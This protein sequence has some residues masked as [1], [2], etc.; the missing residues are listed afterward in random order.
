MRPIPIVP[1]FFAVLSTFSS[2]QAAS[3]ARQ[4]TPSQDAQACYRLI[5]DLNVQAASIAAAAKNVTATRTSFHRVASG[6]SSTRKARLGAFQS[7]VERLNALTAQFQVGW[8]R[9]RANCVVPTNR[10]DLVASKFLDMQRNVSDGLSSFQKIE[11]GEYLK[12]VEPQKDCGSCTNPWQEHCNQ[13]ICNQ[14]CTTC[15]PDPFSWCQISCHTNFLMCMMAGILKETDEVA[16]NV[17]HNM[18]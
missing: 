11:P 6:D 1:T 5:S 10:S 2:L 4:P 7:D 17:I 16:K 8:T 13:A 12:S 15:P 18:N 14:C 9:W 3:P